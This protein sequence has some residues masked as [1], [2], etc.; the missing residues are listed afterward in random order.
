MADYRPF[1]VEG[2]AFFPDSTAFYSRRVGQFD[3][4]IKAFGKVDRN[5]YGFLDALS[6]GESNH[7]ASTYSYD[8][9][10]DASFGIIYS[11]SHVNQQFKADPAEPDDS[12]CFSPGGYMQ[13]RSPAGTASVSFR[14]YMSINS[15]GHPNGAINRAGVSFSPNPGHL[16][17]YFS[18]S[19]IEPG[20]YVRDAYINETGIYDL[21]MG[22]NYVQRPSTGRINTWRVSLG[23][24]RSRLED[25]S[26][27]DQSLSASGWLSTTDEYRVR[28]GWSSGTWLGLANTSTSIGLNWLTRHLYGGGGASYLVGKRDGRDYSYFRVNQGLRPI[29]KFVIGLGFEW[30]RLGSPGVPET[31]QLYTVSGNY[32]VTPE[33]RLGV[34]AV[35]RNSDVNMCVTFTQTVRSGADIY[36]IY[37]YPNTTETTNRW[38]MKVVYPVGF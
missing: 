21:S 17:W 14:R 30:S 33:K 37:G 10:R 32:E 19:D 9:G 3:W 15:D 7:F 22:L 27:H 23:S 35:G 26:I 34:W 11:G 28:F 4:G 25:G 16:G 8:A 12:A 20:Y 13:R 5:V 38:A 2:S 29:E 31:N 6:I 24:Y 18:T 36:L 1:F